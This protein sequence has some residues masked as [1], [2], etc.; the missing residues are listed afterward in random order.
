MA[1]LG[2]QHLSVYLPMCLAPSSTNADFA[3]DSKAAGSPTPWVAQG[4]GPVPGSMEM[5]P[6][7]LPHCG[8]EVTL[9]VRKTLL[10]ASCTSSPTCSLNPLET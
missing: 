3:T 10:C 4:A 7:Q 6:C 9:V 2:L 8:W 5:V 1:E